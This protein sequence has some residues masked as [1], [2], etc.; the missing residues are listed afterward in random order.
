M[1]SLLPNPGSPAPSDSKA[2]VL[3]EPAFFGKYTFHLLLSQRMLW[4]LKIMGRNH[5]SYSIDVIHIENILDRLKTE[6][7]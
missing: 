1:R 6:E 7:I 4:G 2:Q 5:A 3:T